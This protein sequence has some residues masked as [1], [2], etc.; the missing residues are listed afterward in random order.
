MVERKKKKKFERF[1]RGDLP[2]LIKTAR[3]SAATETIF[4]GC[5]FSKRTKKKFQKR[6]LPAAIFHKPLRF[7]IE[8]IFTYA[9]SRAKENQQKRKKKKRSKPIKR[10]CSNWF[11]D[12]I[13]IDK[14]S[15]P[16]FNM[17]ARVKRDRFWIHIVYTSICWWADYWTFDCA[18]IPSAIL[19]F[20]IQRGFGAFENSS[21]ICVRIA[22]LMEKFNDRLS[23]N[24]IYRI[25]VNFY[26]SFA[27]AD[28]KNRIRIIT[29]YLWNYNVTTRPNQFSKFKHSS[30]QTK[31]LIE[32]LVTLSSN[33]LPQVFG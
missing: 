29:M 19:Y 10:N 26:F 28:W 3:L 21:G 4:I 31:N 27:V 18:K 11:T 8:C 30:I 2:S 15:F 25:L 22:R 7:K 33:V 6:C 24:L 23:I 32:K 5:R 17:R 20:I 13:V 14:S 1:R 12:G 9:R 16:C